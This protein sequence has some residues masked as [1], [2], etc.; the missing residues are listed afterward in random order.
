[1]RVEPFV[2]GVLLGAF[3]S[4]KNNQEMFSEMIKK[5]Y[6]FANEYI[7]EQGVNNA[8]NSDDNAEIS[9]EK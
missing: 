5:G 7:A 3:F 8:S 1:M 9:Q 6:K 2:A 4:Q